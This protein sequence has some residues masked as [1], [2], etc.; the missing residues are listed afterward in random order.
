MIWFFIIML[1]TLFLVDFSG[2]GNIIGSI[3]LILCSIVNWLFSVLVI[4]V[5]HKEIGRLIFYIIC[6]C[7]IS[8]CFYCLK[9]NGSHNQI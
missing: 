9:K 7:F 2:E 4:I 8:L 6:L 1:S 3:A 5:G